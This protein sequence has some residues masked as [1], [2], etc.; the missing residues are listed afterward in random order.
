MALVTTFEMAMSAGFKKSRVTLS[1]LRVN[2]PSFAL[3][4]RG[5]GSAWLSG[6]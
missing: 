4:P 3:G 2:S 6:Y 1:N 5:A